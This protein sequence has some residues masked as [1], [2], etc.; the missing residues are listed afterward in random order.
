LVEYIRELMARGLP[1][2]RA[3]IQNFASNILKKHVREGWVSRFINCNYDYL[4]SK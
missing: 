2:T 4:I 3:M 1:P